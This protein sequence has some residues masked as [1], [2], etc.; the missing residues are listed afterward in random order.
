MLKQSLSLILIMMLILFVACSREQKQNDNIRLI[1]ESKKIVGDVVPE[2]QINKPIVIPAG[3]AKIVRA[4]KPVIVQLRSLNKAS[5]LPKEFKAGPPQVCTPGQNGF[6]NPVRIPSAGETFLSGTPEVVVAQ[7]PGSKDYNPHGFYSFGTIQ[8][9]KSNQ[10]RS[11]LQDRNGNLWFNNEDGVTRYDG[12]YLSHFVISNGANKNAIILCM[13]EDKSG[14]LWFG[15]FGGGVLRF[16]GERFTQFT[17]KDGLSN[18]IVNSII[19]DQSGN[20]WIATSGGGVSK[21]DGSGFTH[22]TTKEGLASNQIRSIFQDQSGKIWF[23]TFGKGVSVFD[24]TSFLN[25]SEKEGFPATHLAS[26]I[27][28]KAGNIWFGTYNQ[29][30]I[31]YDGHFFC[32]YTE[33]QG[34]SNNTILCMLQDADGIFWLGTS[35]SGISSFDGKTF[36]NYSEEDGLTNNFI[37]CSLIGRQGN[38]WFGT[39]DGGLVRFNKDLF[40]HYTQNEGLGGNKVLAIKQDKNENFWFGS[41]GGGITRFNGKEFATYSL[42]ETV[43]NDYVYAIL[44][45]ENGTI[46]FGSDG[47]GITNFDGKNFVQFTQNEG[48]CHNAVRCMLKD[49]HNHIWIGTYGNGIS[50][51]D[52]KNFVNYSE[53]EGLSSNKVMCMLEDKNDNMWFGTD[54]GGVTKFD[55]KNFTH[56]SV[57]EGLNSNAIASIL[58]DDKGNLWFGSSGGGVTRYD[59]TSLTVFNKTEGLSNNY[60]TSLLQDK[61]G[62]I[63]MGSRFGPNILSAAHIHNNNEK[64]PPLFKNFSYDDG[65][66]GIGCNLGALYEDRNGIIWIGSTNRLSAINPKADIPD[67][68]PPNIRLTNI[69]LFGENIPWLK[70]SANKDTSFVLGNGVTV[71]NFKF[72][73]I[74][75]WYFLPENLNLAHNHNFLTFSFI[76]ISQKQTQ[77]IR[78]Q[79][80]LE[81]LDNQWSAITDLTEI[82]YGNL[83][84]GH[85]LF[86]VK[87]INSLGIRSDEA[88][89]SFSIQYPWWETWWFYSIL[90]LISLLVIFIFI[91]WREREH[92]IQKKQLNNKIEEQ[93]YE[94]KEKNFELEGKN[95]DLQIANSEKDKFFSIIAHDVRGPLSSFLLFTEVMAENLHSYSMEELQVMAESMK[96]S[97]ETLFELLENLLEWARMQRGLIQYNPERLIIIDVLNNTI[98][99]IIQPAKNKSITLVI[100]ISADMTVLADKNMLASILRNLISNAIKFTPKGGKV[101]LTAQPIENGLVEIRVMDTGIGIDAPMLK[102]LFKMDAYCNRVGTDGESSAGLGLLLC[103]DFI[104]KQGGRIWVESEVGNGSS[105]YFTLKSG[106]RR[107]S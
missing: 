76:G 86:K 75:K 51:F 10:M 44:E 101:T 29:G 68:V 99:A 57:K 90:V 27:Q 102:E 93:T 34:L 41:F 58:E 31:R 38:L 32:Q 2:N 80:Q 7:F 1:S 14:T 47:G 49:H 42:K 96:K 56:I 30:I 40:T 79:Y 28:D 12:K 85:Y 3:N 22:Y 63:W 26:I 6:S 89:Y 23:G 92:E 66:L 18:N 45:G 98:D 9:L 70:I 106:S 48:L 72:T 97:A 84:P 83:K 4:Q 104:E 16:D 74:S 95:T 91:K 107:P 24:G 19:Q 61:K 55:G 50:R 59:G 17:E 5:A 13:L 20:Y 87:A 94:L 105:F 100:D 35:G 53:K 67:T 82:S 78:Y 25:F 69:Q 62:N 43:L 8:G 37:R 39:R 33:K 71:E 73:A 60:I 64:S 15:T 46:W 103:K 36:T 54:D 81:G 52:G 65:F 77:K 88:R 21:F 11:M